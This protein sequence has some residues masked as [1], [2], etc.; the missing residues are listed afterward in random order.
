MTF[1]ENGSSGISIE[2]LADV[3]GVSHL[4]KKKSFSWSSLSFL[5]NGLRTF[6]IVFAF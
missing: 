2:N 1:P 3:L 5:S 4:S 6:Q